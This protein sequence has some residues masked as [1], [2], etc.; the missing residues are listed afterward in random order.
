MKRIISIAVILA[1][2]LSCALI[3]IVPTAAQDNYL[4]YTALDMHLLGD[5]TGWQRFGTTATSPES[6]MATDYDFIKNAG[7][8]FIREFKVPASGVLKID[9][10]WTTGITMGSDPS[11]DNYPIKYAITDPNGKIVFPTNG[12]LGSVTYTNPVTISQTSPLTFNV[13]KDDVYSFILIDE[14]GYQ[15]PTRFMA[16]VFVNDVQCDSS[17]HLRGANYNAQG[18]GGWSY[19]YAESVAVSQN[20]SFAELQNIIAEAEGYTEQQLEQYTYQSIMKFNAALDAAKEITATSPAKDI[21]TAALA[22]RSA[23]DGLELPKAQTVLEF[24]AKEMV[25]L[26]ASAW[27][28]W[29]NKAQG[30]T[31]ITTPAEDYIQ[32]AQAATIREFTVPNSGTLQI[33]TEWTTGLTIGN[34]WTPNAYAKYAIAD[35]NGKILFPRDGNLGE[36]RYGTPVTISLSD[37]VL[38]DVLAG[39]KIYFV[40]IDEQGSGAPILF[41]ARVT[42][43]A[44]TYGVNG[45][46]RGQNCNAQGEDGWRYLYANSVSVVTKSDL[47]ELNALIVEAEQAIAD[48]TLNYTAES[49]ANLQTALQAAKQ[50]T[51]TS[52]TN[53]ITAATI[54]LKNAIDAL[55]ETSLQQFLEYQPQEMVLLDETAWVRWGDTEQGYTIITTPAE[56]YIQKA[57]AATIREFTVPATGILQIDTEWT[58]GLTIGNE[59]TPNAYAKYAIT[60][61]N[62]KVLFPKNGKLG[63]V[64]NGTPVTISVNDPLLIEVE[65]GDTINFVTIDEQ[66]SGAPIL[67]NARVVM[68]NKTYC[69]NGNLRGENCNAQGEGGWRYLYA[70]SVS[71]IAKAD[72]T[73]VNSLIK[74]AEKILDSGASNYTKASVDSLKTVL[75]TAKAL[76]STSAQKDIDEVED[77]LRKALS[78]LKIKPTDNSVKRLGFTPKRLQFDEDTA[79]WKTDENSSCMMTASYSI[80][81]KVSDGYV[82]I[83]KMVAPRAGSMQIKYGNGVYIDNTSGQFDGATVEFAIADKFGRIIFPTNG[84]TLTIEH[85]KMYPIEMSLN[86]VAVGDSFYFMV[87]KPST[88]NIPVVMHMGV[89]ISNFAINNESGFLYGLDGAQGA[90]S[91]FYMYANDLSFYIDEG[92]IPDNDDEEDNDN[93]QNSGSSD[94]DNR[95]DSDY[96][97]SPATSDTF[98]IKKAI[99]AFLSTVIAFSV[100]AGIKFKKIKAHM[101]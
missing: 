61:K 44:T 23:I 64:R 63:T 9:T 98:G 80:S 95:L 81:S 96:T 31:I 38:V 22:L 3:G 40:T 5:G 16:R 52:P 100:F 92:K 35:K 97:Q 12:E 75:E 11:H 2:V 85:D 8:A 17:G 83:R 94:T 48:G 4:Q 82:A 45:C 87:F 77:N 57:G 66:G 46:L 32:K 41:N 6:F 15:I 90:S 27:V 84:G 93:N 91:W 13:N 34:E 28:R 99:A 88:D 43:G 60:D 47:T 65:A 21:T 72:L 68:F 30:Y 39:D 19:K 101:G 55:E 1:I 79:L 25:L 78:E 73:D 89:S 49:I 14:Y 42:M 59:W 33:D 24:D 62:G 10:E 53:D 26:D 69:V 29:G 51:D 76:T 86:N 74:K 70:N 67:F 54:A 7:Y 58:T 18:E 37:P 71:V 56:D 20:I 50:I 36:V